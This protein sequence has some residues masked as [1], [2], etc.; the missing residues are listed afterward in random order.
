MSSASNYLLETVSQ[1]LVIKFLGAVVFPLFVYWV[2]WIFA[3][4]NTPPISP[5]KRRWFFLAFFLLGLLITQAGA[6]VV[7]QWVA[8]TQGAA[9]FQCEL[10]DNPSFGEAILE[11]DKV[12]LAIFHMYVYNNGSE[13]VVTKWKCTAKIAGTPIISEANRYPFNITLTNS[14]PSRV[15]ENVKYLPNALWESPLNRGA[16]RQGWV[17]FKF[18]PKL[19]DDLT[20]AGIEYTVELEDRQHNIASVNWKVPA[21]YSKP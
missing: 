8:F 21:G 6:L 18:P 10:T 1:D 13:S 11:N 20:R 12:S 9:R 15:F 17:A 3:K 16:G 5:A 2:H 19:T 14:A 7:R 4:E